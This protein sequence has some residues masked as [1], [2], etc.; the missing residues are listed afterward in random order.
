MNKCILN[1]KNLELIHK[2][3]FVFYASDKMIVYKDGS[4]LYAQNCENDIIAKIDC[5]LMYYQYEC[6]SVENGVVLLFSGKTLIYIDLSGNFTIDDIPVYKSGRCLLE[7]FPSAHKNSIILVGY[8]HKQI[9]IM[10]YDFINK[11]RLYQTSSWE[12][13]QVNDVYCLDNKIYI[14]M[15]SS[16]LVC[17]DASTGE[18]LWT[19]FESGKIDP[20]VFPYDNGIIY[21]CHNVIKIINNDDI[22]TIQVPLSRPERLEAIINNKLYYVSNNKTHLCC[23]NLSTEKLEWELP[24]ARNIIKT[25]TC[26]GISEHKKYNIMLLQAS[27]IIIVLNL[28]TGTTNNYF[29]MSNIY[30]IKKTDNHILIQKQLET[31]MLA[32]ELDVE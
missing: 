12:V 10:A 11:K 7:I 13:S 19:K 5:P 17:C 6:L 24:G 28:D 4:F 2:R 32:G 23:F 20:R 29:P 22:K 31:H 14:L 18:T 25:I 21:L 26:Q 15:N 9:H 30:N 16:Y 8:L 27:G 1:L 3:Y